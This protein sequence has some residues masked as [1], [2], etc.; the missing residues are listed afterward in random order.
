MGEGRGKG[1]LITAGIRE[2]Y[3]FSWDK[4]G[5]IYEKSLTQNFMPRFWSLKLNHRDTCARLFNTVL[6]VTVKYLE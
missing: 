3:F 2:Q 6:A 1:V 5:N 4:F